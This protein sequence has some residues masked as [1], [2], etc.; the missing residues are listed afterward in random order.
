MTNPSFIHLFIHGISEAT[1]VY[2]AL[3][4]CW[5]GFTVSLSLFFWNGIYLPFINT[6][7]LDTFVSHYT[8]PIRLA[9]DWFFFPFSTCYNFIFFQR[10]FC[11]HLVMHMNYLIYLLNWSLL[12]HVPALLLQ[13]FSE[14][15][16]RCMCKYLL[17]NSKLYQFTSLPFYLVK[18]N[19]YPIHDKF[20]AIFLTYCNS[21][22]F[23]Y[24]P[25]D[26][27]YYVNITIGCWVSEW[28]NKCMQLL[29]TAIGNKIHEHIILTFPLK[30][31]FSSEKLNKIF[32]N[33]E[34]H[35]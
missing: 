2:Q 3:F 34:I 26:P 10:Y 28:I 1:T 27:K 18:V 6:S 29:V 25:K 16:N 15:S 5:Y 32:L 35:A 4:F 24:A 23:R 22:L 20:H 9:E 13:I 12:I 30:F 11:L 19:W 33:H 7:L 21:Y 17:R 8:C 14:F 31:S